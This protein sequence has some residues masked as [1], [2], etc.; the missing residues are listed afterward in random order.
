MDVF[1][2][3]HARQLPLDVD[4]FFSTAHNRL[5]HM[6]FDDGA[7]VPETAPNRHQYIPSV[8]L[9]YGKQYYLNTTADLEEAEAEDSDQDMDTDDGVLAEEEEENTL[10]APLPVLPPSLNTKSANSGGK[11]SVKVDKEQWKSLWSTGAQE[12]QRSSATVAGHT[13]EGCL[14]TQS[15]GNQPTSSYNTWRQDVARLEGSSLAL[16]SVDSDASCRLNQGAVTMNVQSMNKAVRSHE[17]RLYLE[18]LP[19]TPP[20]AEQE[21]KK[22]KRIA[23]H[24]SIL[25]SECRMQS[26]YKNSEQPG[27]GPLPKNTSLLLDPTREVPTTG[28]G[29]GKRDRGG[30]WQMDKYVDDSGYITVSGS[31]DEEEEDLGCQ[32]QTKAEANI[33]ETSQVLGWRDIFPIG[34]SNKRQKRESTSVDPE[35]SD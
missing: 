11:Q 35:S 8:S 7:V 12:A 13:A 14:M 18:P 21:L 19:K 23:A 24:V 28:Y 15:S 25:D 9:D 4:A 3:L 17:Q 6:L 34:S 22:L 16:P 30:L 29:I 20:S 27:Y 26:K 1:R 32:R 31:D 5:Q 10:E 33:E 2:T